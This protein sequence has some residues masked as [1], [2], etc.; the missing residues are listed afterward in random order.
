MATAPTG[1]IRQSDPGIRRMQ[2]FTVRERTV[3]RWPAKW[4]RGESISAS[5]PMQR[6]RSLLLATTAAVTIGIGVPAKAPA[7]FLWTTKPIERLA[8]IRAAYLIT[9]AR[10]KTYRRQDACQ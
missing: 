10:R 6:R 5:E 7:P 3:P 1:T 2:D 9:Y 8:S 4:T